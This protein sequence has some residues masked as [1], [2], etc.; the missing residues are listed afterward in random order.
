MNLGQPINFGAKDSVVIVRFVNQ[1]TM[2]HG[3]H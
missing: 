1:R 3:T 2:A